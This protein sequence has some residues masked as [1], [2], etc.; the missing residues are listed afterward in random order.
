M[1]KVKPA[2]W[3]AAVLAIVGV[4]LS[5]PLHAAA[6][7]VGPW[8]RRPPLRL[9]LGQSTAELC[10]EILQ[11]YTVKRVRVNLCTEELPERTNVTIYRRDRQVQTLQLSGSAATEPLAPGRYWVDAGGRKTAFTVAENA[12]ITDVSGFG[13]TDGEL[14][15]LTLEENADAGE[16]AQRGT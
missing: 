13:C 16:A 9:E 11:L 14:L 4:L 12:S 7:N 3:T 15:W 2:V 8:P 5:L 10:Q 1:Q 6:V